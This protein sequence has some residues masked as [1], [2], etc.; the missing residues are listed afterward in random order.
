M[1]LCLILRLKLGKMSS[2]EVQPEFSP[3][4]AQD[5]RAKGQNSLSAIDSPSH[6]RLLHS[7]ADQVLTVRLDDPTSDW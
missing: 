7:G 4:I 3:A 6:S 5:Q 1:G 2:K